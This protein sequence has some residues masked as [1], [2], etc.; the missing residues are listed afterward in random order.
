MFV[1]EAKSLKGASLV[2]YGHKKFY[3]IGL[4]KELHSGR[5]QLC[6]Q[7][8]DS[9]LANTL[10]YYDTANVTA[11]VSFI[12]QPPDL[13]FTGEAGYHTKGIRV[14]LYPYK[15]IRLWCN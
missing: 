3:N 6:L 12:E 8:P 14:G 9:N 13:I 10:A 2:I 15:N 7:M 11:V 1:G 5:L 4:C